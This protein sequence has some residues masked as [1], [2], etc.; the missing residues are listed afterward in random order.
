M[1]V[2]AAEQASYKMPSTNQRY[3][4]LQCFSVHVSCMNT[5]AALFGLA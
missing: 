2:S 4:L 5:A 3:F 1:P